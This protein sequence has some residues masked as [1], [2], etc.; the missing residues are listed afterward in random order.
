[1]SGEQ[2]DHLPEVRHAERLAAAES[3][4]RNTER[5]DAAGEVERFVAIELVAPGPVRT[6]LLAA[7]DAACCA[8][9]GKL[10]G[11]KKGRAVFMYR[12]PRH[13]GPLDYL[14]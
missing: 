6:G 14:R 8:A 1:M 10:P 7:G 12:A 2:L 5:N 9:V 11:K 13:C 4:I 3:D